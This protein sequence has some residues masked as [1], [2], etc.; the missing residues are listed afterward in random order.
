VALENRENLVRLIN[1]YITSLIQLR[2]ELED[3]DREALGRRLENAWAGRAR[4]FEERVEAEWLNKEAQKI[5]APSFGERVNQMLF[6]SALSDRTKK[7][8]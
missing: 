2:D 8:K 4:W 5:D 1:S 3:G 6:G 7:P